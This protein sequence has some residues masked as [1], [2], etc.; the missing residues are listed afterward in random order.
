MVDLGAAL[1]FLLCGP[2]RPKKKQAIVGGKKFP[3][4]EPCPCG[5][6]RKY[7]KCC[8]GTAND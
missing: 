7:K 5:S 6:D 2:A 4:N 8:G 1:A 3:R